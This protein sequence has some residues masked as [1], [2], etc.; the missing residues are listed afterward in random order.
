MTLR[1]LAAS[2]LLFA[3]VA[4]PALAADRDPTPEERAQME[5]V[6]RAQGF[7]QWDD[8][9]LEAD[10]QLWEVDDAKTADGRSYDL[11]LRPQSYDIVRRT[12]DD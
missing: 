10:D 11:K 1:R 8:I 2:A 6:L 4:A 9:E 12:L 5:K 7:V 3:A